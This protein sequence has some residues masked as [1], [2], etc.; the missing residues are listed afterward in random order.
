M[1]CWDV[2]S[3]NFLQNIFQSVLAR[4]ASDTCSSNILRI[5]GGEW[6]VY[7]NAFM[8]ECAGRLVLDRNRVKGAEL[9]EIMDT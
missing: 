2:V 5:F 3:H 8:G 1:G 7:K 9:L 4:T 6:R